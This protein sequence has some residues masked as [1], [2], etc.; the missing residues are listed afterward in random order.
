MDHEQSPERNRTL[1]VEI[2]SR[3][4][5]ARAAWDF[6]TLNTLIT[7]D[8]VTVIAG[9]R[10]VCPICGAYHGKQGAHDAVRALDAQ[11]ELLS[12]LTPLLFIVEGDHVAMRLTS[13][14]RSRGTGKSLQFETFN[15]IIFNGDLI[16]TNTIYLDTAKVVSFIEWS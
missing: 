1:K 12:P 8:Y 3:Y 9:D 15:H 2:V 5:K 13:H 10:S 7:D 16:R 14:W 4:L 11:F 6:K